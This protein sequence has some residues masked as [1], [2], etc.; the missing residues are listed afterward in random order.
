[1]I[2]LGLTGRDVSLQFYE[3]EYPKPSGGRVLYIVPGHIRVVAI[4][5]F[6]R[7]KKTPE[8]NLF[9]LCVS[10]RLCFG[11]RKTMNARHSEFW[12]LHDTASVVVSVSVV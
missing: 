2:P 12:A 5:G 10:F 3:I 4:F 8:G 9:N 6:C 1:M 11:L 7:R